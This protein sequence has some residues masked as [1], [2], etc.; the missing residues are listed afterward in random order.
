MQQLEF[1][2]DEIADIRA[3]AT[4]VERLRDL[5][6]SFTMHYM[7]TDLLGLLANCDLSKAQ[8]F[9]DEVF[10][11]EEFSRCNTFQALLQ[12]LRRNHIDTFN[13]YYLQR[14]V[15]YFK[16]DE[17]KKP[18]EKYEAEKD[19]FLCDTKVIEFQHAVVSRVESV[20]PN[21]TAVITIRVT[22][23]LAKDR[24]LKDIE[25]LALRGF[26][27]C[28]RTFIRIHAK[29]GSVIISWF[30]PEALS[31]K[32]EHLARENASVF[33]DAGVQEVTVAGRVVFPSTLE[34]V[35][36]TVNQKSF[37]KKLKK[38]RDDSCKSKGTRWDDSCK[39]KGTRWDDSCK[40]KGTRW[41]DSCKSKGTRWDDSCKSKGT[42]W[43][44]TCRSK[45]RPSE[46]RPTLKCQ[47]SYISGLSYN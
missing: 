13:T 39:S 21:Q 31:G 35:R 29:S 3:A 42:R 26:G 5:E 8:F 33:K 38:C 10:E 6:I 12:Q 17:L 19:T 37:N 22:R 43:D 30:F 16:K 34:E 47:V 25:E 44:D 9:L 4:V 20:K 28:Q 46:P 18:I 36:T 24:T 40:S 7:L 45:T 27:E 1:S 41:D 32:L 11:T 2:T 15:A 14:L 23:T